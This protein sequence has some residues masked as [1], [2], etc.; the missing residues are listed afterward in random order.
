MSN[1]SPNRL[2]LLDAYALIFRAYYAFIKSPRINS[3]GLNTSAIFGFANTVLDVI[4]KEKP[5][6]IGVAFDPP[7]G[8]FRSE[9]FEAYKANRA[10]TPEDIKASVPY[11][12]EFLKAMGIPILIKEGFEA[13]DVI[14]TLAQRAAQQNFE[15]YIMT[16]DKDLSQL[17]ND[18]I[19]I[20][21]P[22]SFGKEAHVLRAPDI[23]ERY[24]IK[25]PK[26]IIDILGM[27]GD[28]VDNIPGI[29]GVGEKTA[30][31]LIGEFGSMEN[32]LANANNI[33]GKLGENIRNFAEQGRMSYELATIH[34]SVPIDFEPESLVL[35]SPNRDQ[36]TELFTELEFRSMIKR[37]LGEEA[38]L[39]A[40]T[41]GGQ[42]S[43]FGNSETTESTVASYAAFKT[44]E[45]SSVQYNHISAKD[46]IPKLLEQTDVCFDTETDE[47]DSHQAS[48]VG[49][50]FS[51][52]AGEAWYV[53]V[54]KENEKQ[55][56][57][58]LRPFFESETIRKIGQNLKYDL[59]V[60]SNYGILVK[61]ELFDTM[62]A[63][64]LLH[65][66]S[67]HGMEFLAEQYL[68]YSPVSIEKLIG[69]KGKQ[70][71]N[72]RDVALEEITEYACED[73][74]ITLQLKE[75]F[76][77]LITG[78]HLEILSE[79][80]EMPL[81]RV[82]SS[83]ESEGIAIDT[84]A[85]Q[86]FGKE[87]EIDILSEQERIHA[88]AGVPFNIDSPK[89][90]GE[91]L[92]DHLKIDAKAKKTKTGQYA[93]NE[94]VLSTLT[95]KHDIVKH[96]LEY[97][98]LRKLKN[99]YVD[100]LPE[101]VNARTGR[102]HTTYLQT[103][104]ATGRLSSNNPNL[105][106]IPI[107]TERG[108][109]IRKAFIP[110]NNDFLILSADYSQIE[111][112][113]IAALAKDEFMIDAFRKGEDI[114]ASTA[115]RVFG[116]SIKDVNREM[117][118][119]AKAVNFGIIY[120]QT[121][122]GLS[123]TLGISRTEA[124]EIIDNYFSMFPRIQGYI[125]ES[126]EFAKQ[127]GYAETIMGRRRYLPDIH[128]AN[129]VVRGQAE[130]NAINAPIQGSAADIIKVAMISVWNSLQQQNL[131]S[132]LLLQ[133]HDELVIDLFKP[134]KEIVLNILKTC[135]E[136]AAELDVPLVVEM[137]AAENWLEAH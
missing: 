114:H 18:K 49:L 60:L 74:D 67:K 23:C 124:K 83:M 3:K 4:N 131:K 61:G 39:F 96:I 86:I 88:L 118:S 103:V 29:P 107:K 135:M 105:Q 30:F 50:S 79:K 6:H 92:F 104:A 48:L 106:N 54:S 5:T 63:H 68:G 69:K 129:Q 84:K 75:V 110:R 42:M 9:Q 76:A 102:I 38:T 24:Q 2:Y 53:A 33:K 7:G 55:I 71:G 91:V 47:L 98:G 125:A 26:Q 65:P 13:D 112:R 44:L 89:Q 16:S 57:E 136:Q 128:S 37:V 12:F 109:Y 134:E 72:M 94:D 40:G 77:P 78:S 101:L 1:E 28:S 115:A 58:V 123:Q 80:V 31:K 87:L 27:M 51:W 117:R 17:V 15:V 46:L 126:I 25:N 34:T 22:A 116:V 82:L 70:Q 90:L 35:S 45:K 32:V 119:K 81:I 99:T 113:I 19:F 133:V 132:R 97:R 62:V 108:R 66:E 127:K 10:E 64:Y 20:Y 130:R 111:L 36:V 52:V 120:G 41:T 100:P 11:I 56:V 43:L 73:A 21:R 122:F 93:T 121:A 8:T 137:N 59:N 95:E 14:G 85:L